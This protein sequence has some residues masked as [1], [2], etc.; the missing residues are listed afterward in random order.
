MEPP[1]AWAEQRRRF[2]T[3]ENNAVYVRNRSEMS[4]TAVIGDKNISR[5]LDLQIN[6]WSIA[7]QV[8]YETIDIIMGD[9]K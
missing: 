8:L 4:G 3:E 1:V 2:R 5:V 7:Y 6:R 9:R